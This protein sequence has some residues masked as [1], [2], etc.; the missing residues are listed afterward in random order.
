[1]EFT[2]K[3]GTYAC[4]YLPFSQAGSMGNDGQSST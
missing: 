4:L 2:D 1:M 3:E